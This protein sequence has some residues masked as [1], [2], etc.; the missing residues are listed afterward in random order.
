MSRLHHVFLDDLWRL[1]IGKMGCGRVIVYVV[2][3]HA[4]TQLTS[5]S[6]VIGVRSCEAALSINTLS[7]VSISF[8]L[9]LVNRRRGRG[10]AIFVA[11]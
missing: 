7:Q 9:V 1:R 11:S 6:T 5:S 4:P 10:A 3:L 8:N 2:H